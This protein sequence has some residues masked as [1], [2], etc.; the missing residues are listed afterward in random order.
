MGRSRNRSG[1]AGGMGGPGGMMGGESG[2]GGFQV[3]GSVG[4][5][6]SEAIQ[7]EI[8]GIINIFNSPDY[9]DLAAAQKAADEKA[10]EAAAK[11]VS[12]LGMEPV[13]PATTGTTD[14]TVPASDDDATVDTP[15][16]VE[17]EDE[18]PGF[19]DDPAEPDFE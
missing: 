5:Y 13:T 10:Q 17:D 16:D 7:I 15:G 9:S 2:S 18:E 3:S 8:F 11:A 19:D 14:A 4:I 1:G 6:S 12:P